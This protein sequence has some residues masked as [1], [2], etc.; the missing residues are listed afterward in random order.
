MSETENKSSQMDPQA[1]LPGRSRRMLML[2]GAGLLAATA[3]AGF[4]WWRARHRPD[5]AL[6]LEP[7]AGFWDLQWDSPQGEP[8]RL[9]EF[10]G[11]PLLI[12]FWVWQLTSQ[13]PSRPS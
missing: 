2:G 8:I 12:N 11:K 13:L 10:R 3:G 9:Q 4:A 7:P 1:T 6:A 5:A